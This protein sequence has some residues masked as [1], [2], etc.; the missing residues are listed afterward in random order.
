MSGK[1]R[2]VENATDTQTRPTMS[3]RWLIFL[4][5]V[6][7]VVVLL[8]LFLLSGSTALDGIKRFF[9]Y[10]GVDRETYGAIDFDHFGS[11]ECCLVNDRLAIATQ[12]QLTVYAEDGAVLARH[13]GS[14]PS[15]ALTSSEKY[16]LAY[17]I[18]G[19]HLAVTDADGKLRFELDASGLIYDAALAESGA[20]CVLT[21]SS[22]CRA[23]LE[24]Y[25]K[26]GSLLFRRNSKTNYLNTCALSPNHEFVAATTLGQENI[27]FSASAQVFDTASD[28]VYAEIPLG[29]QLIY[30]LQFLDET[31][32]CAVGENSLVFF[33]ADGAIL[34]EYAADDSELMAYSFGGDGYVA[35]LYDSFNANGRYRLLTMDESGTVIAE[36]SLDHTPL[37]LSACKEYV[38]V[39]S[40]MTLQIFNRELKEQNTAPNSIW[41]TVLIRSDGTAY[42][43]APDEASL[44]IP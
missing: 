19:N 32:L 42:C 39:L 26:N 34:G 13:T 22:S 27:A 44:L 33:T 31:T 11:V 5:I 10:G 28:T 29:A 1:I 37:S 14:Y 6:L 3:H 9:R 12:E 16:L 2:L 41:Q 18:G 36:A 24:V 8:G 15:A 38:A 17:D 35:A 7:V 25:S 43:I 40:D 21:D 23:V 30:D 4:A 20:V